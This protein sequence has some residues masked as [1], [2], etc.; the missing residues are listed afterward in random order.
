MQVRLKVHKMTAAVAI[1]LALLIFEIMVLNHEVQ[2]CVSRVKQMEEVL[3]EEANQI[4]QCIEALRYLSDVAKLHNEALVDQKN[5]INKHTKALA[6]M[7]SKERQNA[8]Q[9]EDSA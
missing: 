6:V 8:G 9:Q 2:N 5:E 7:I 1:V 3:K 4:Q